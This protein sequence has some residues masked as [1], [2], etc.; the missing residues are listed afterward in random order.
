[1]S[2]KQLTCNEEICNAS[3]FLLAKKDLNILKYQIEIKP[4]KIFVKNLMNSTHCIYCI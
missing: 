3:M 1:M 2:S 4:Y